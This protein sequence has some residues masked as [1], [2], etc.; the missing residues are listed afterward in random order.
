MFDNRFCVESPGILPGIVRLNNMREV[1]FSRNPKIAA[2]LHEY[3]YVQEFGEGVDRMYREMAEASLPEP[4]YKDVSF[5]LIATVRNSINITKNDP[6]NDPVNAPVKLNKT[7][8]SI[9]DIIIKNPNITRE[10]IAI[11]SK[12]S[13]ATIRRC[14]AELKEKGIIARVGSAK[15]GYWKVL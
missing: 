9:L 1:H 8:Q 15:T 2:Y 5:M 6:V 12:K 3:D 11:K 14:I 7:Q 4:E 13:L 10:E